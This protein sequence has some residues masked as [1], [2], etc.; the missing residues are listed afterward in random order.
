MTAARS[1]RIGH[2]A[3]VSESGELR[4]GFDFPVEDDWVPPRHQGP[5]HHYRVTFHL[6]LKRGSRCKFVFDVATRFGPLKAVAVAMDAHRSR[7]ERSNSPLCIDCEDLGKPES[8]AGLLEATPE[9]IE[10]PGSATRYQA[11][12][13]WG[14]WD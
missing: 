2:Y 7:F 14:L 8:L 6:G 13:T 4:P 3:L 12:L 5:W 1:R 11:M 10:K 9:R